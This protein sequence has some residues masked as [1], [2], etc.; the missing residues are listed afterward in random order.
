MRDKMKRVELKFD[1]DSIQQA[2]EMYVNNSMYGTYNVVNMDLPQ[3][4]EISVIVELQDED[5]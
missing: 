5:R 1:R 4:K 3:D 2:L